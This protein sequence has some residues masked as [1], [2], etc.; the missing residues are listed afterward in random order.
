MAPTELEDISLFLPSGGRGRLEGVVQTGFYIK[1]HTLPRLSGGLFRH[2]ARLA[3]ALVFERV[4]E[5]AIVS[6]RKARVCLDGLP[7]DKL[8]PTPGDRIENPSLES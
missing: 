2:P 4:G 1:V 6:F 5:I 8:S 7:R 3:L